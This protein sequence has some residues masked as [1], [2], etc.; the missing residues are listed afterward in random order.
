MKKYITIGLSA[1]LC[2][3]IFCSCSADNAGN[4]DGNA[5]NGVVSDHVSDKDGAFEDMIS[6]AED[7]VSDAGDMMNDMM[8]GAED[9]V[10]DTVSNGRDI[11]DDATGS[12]R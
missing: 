3:L 8:S 6:G 10:S 7:M 11:I 2:A 9:T 4:T 12:S 1:A 5:E